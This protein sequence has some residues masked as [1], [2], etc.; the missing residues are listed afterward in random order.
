[1]SLPI[2][3]TCAEKGVLCS[4]C[5]TKQQ[6]GKITDL[7]VRISKLL[8]EMGE[9][10]IGFEKAI[11]T[12]GFIIILTQKENI[13]KINGK[14]GDNIRHLSNTLGKQIRVIGTGNLEDIIYDFVAPARISSINTVYKTDG[15]V[16]ERVKI[17]KKDKKKLR[18]D[19]KEIERLIR[20]LTDESIVIVF[21]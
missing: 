1:M 20:S 3:N 21:D 10:G 14:G 16:I 11:D 5:K 2:C 19:I 7:D 4:K 6:K 15:E 13:G 8:Y 18:M 12:K 9:G 17:N